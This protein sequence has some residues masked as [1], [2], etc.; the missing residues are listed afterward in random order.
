MP[1]RDDQLE[2]ETLEGRTR[3]ITR[4]KRRK[5]RPEVMGQPDPKSLRER[6][7]GALGEKAFDVYHA[8]RTR[9]GQSIQGARQIGAGAASL[10]ARTGA[11]LRRTTV[12]D[13]AGMGV[14]R[15][16]KPTLR[17]I[18]K[19]SQERLEVNPKTIGE[20]QELSN[21]LHRR[22]RIEQ[23]SRAELRGKSRDFELSV[24]A[25]NSW[26]MQGLWKD[27]NDPKWRASKTPKEIEEAWDVYMRWRRDLREQVQQPMIRKPILESRR[28]KA[29]ST[30]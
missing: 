11:A 21:Q 5:V 27:L 16:T 15:R 9:A 25:G 18:T 2:V 3:R 24:A 30:L 1:P 10:A 4:R 22:Y 7:G 6:V 19:P 28:R 14:S 12:A 23:R 26:A 20:L 8:V 29:E 17:G 13:V